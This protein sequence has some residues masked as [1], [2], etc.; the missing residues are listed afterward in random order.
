MINQP[1]DTLMPGLAAMLTES[2]GELERADL[3]I[4]AGSQELSIG[5]TVSPCATFAIRCSAGS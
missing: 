2:K 5:V 4:K 1:I 3:T